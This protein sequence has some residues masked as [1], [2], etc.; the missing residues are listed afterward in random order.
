MEE[1]HVYP[2][3]TYKETKAINSSTNLAIFK[4]YL[5]FAL[6]LLIT[7][8]VS[9][10]IPN[11][12]IALIETSE[13]PNAIATGYTIAMVISVVLMIPA[14]IVMAVQSFRRNFP[15]MLV[16]YILYSVAMGVLLS[17]I[18][19]NFVGSGSQGIYTIC[20]AFF[21]TGS[22]FLIMGLLTAFTKINFHAFIPIITTLAIGALTISLVNF[23][24][25][26]AMIYWIVEFVIFG[27][28]IIVVGID[29]YNIKKIA[30]RGGFDNPNLALYCAFSLYT[31]FIWIFIRILYY[32]MIFSR[33]N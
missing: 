13:D 3:R 32:L 8:V 26:S 25:G 30:E 20:T 31:D 4:V 10:T 2:E 15:L 24:L 33:R 29:T 9:L 6:G 1:Y 23:F 16:T 21:A 22:I 14:T 11:L 5:W 12:L 27:I 19:L 17:S 7:G 18:M 28:M